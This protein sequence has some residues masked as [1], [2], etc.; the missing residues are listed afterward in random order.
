M[1]DIL[2]VS[3]NTDDAGTFCLENAEVGDH[4]PDALG[5][6]HLCLPDNPTATDATN[7]RTAMLNRINITGTLLLNYRGHGALNTWGGSPVIMSTSHLTSWNNPTKPVVI[8][9]GDCLDG[10]FA[11]P[12]TEGLGEIYLRAAGKGTAAHWSS[13]GLG[14]ST[15]HSVLVEALYDGI[16]EESVTAVGDASNFAKFHFNMIGGHHSILYSFIVEG[17]PAMHLMRPDLNV[18]KTALQVEGEPGDTAEFVIEVS[19]QGVYPSHVTVT[20]TLPADLNFLSY[21]STL[22]T[23]MT[24]VGNDIVFNVQFGNG[25]LNKGLPRN[26]SAIITITTQVDSQA[27]AGIVYNL[28]AAAGTGSDAWPGDESDTAM[29]EIIIDIIPPVIFENFIPLIRR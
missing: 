19:N 17:D 4:I 22:S 9:T 14:L 1:E 12:T 16:F 13:S 11:Y 28:A 24:V 27:E 3:D 26:S 10:Y 2:F 15:E 8:L 29:F 21:Q 6:I 20:D 7:L 5:E 18:E 25:P 23:T